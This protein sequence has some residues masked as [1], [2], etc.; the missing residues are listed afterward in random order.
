MDLLGRTCLFAVAQQPFSIQN[1]RFASLQPLLLDET[2]CNRQAF[3]NCGLVWWLVTAETEHLATPGR[4]VIGELELA[5]RWRSEDKS[6]MLYQV[7]PGTVKA[8]PSDLFACVV[9]CPEPNVTGIDDFLTERFRHQSIFPLP[10]TVFVRWNGFL[11]GPFNAECTP[12]ERKPNYS[13]SLSVAN[14]R[15]TVVQLSL[16]QHKSEILPLLLRSECKI[17]L[18]ERS[19]AMDGA[20][21][22]YLNITIVTRA[23]A[24]KLLCLEGTRVHLIDESTLLADFAR[25][26]L[27]RRQRQQLVEL[28]TV[29]LDKRGSLVDADDRKWTEARDSTLRLIQRLESQDERIRQLVSALHETG[30]IMNLSTRADVA[31]AQ[32]AEDLSRSVAMKRHELE[33]LCSEVD[34]LKSS[35]AETRARLMKEHEAKL[36]ESYNRIE[37]L[38][39]FLQS[40]VN[41]QLAFLASREK[42]IKDIAKTMLALAAQGHESLLPSEFEIFLGSLLSTQ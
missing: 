33:E 10:K 31:H 41:A 35:L 42:R 25:S 36:A 26:V 17:S 1:T 18:N 16:S 7:R 27:S 12:S 3:P 8:A 38:R 15:N 29:A 24:D 28:L 2:A 21:I 22:A 20:D 4:L 37:T 9:D 40:E 5:P 39:E 34:Q 13:L 30:Y 14:D 19:P 11:T 32:T 6:A 23:S